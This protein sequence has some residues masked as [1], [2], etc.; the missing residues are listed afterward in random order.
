MPG[1]TVAQQTGTSLAMIK[2][3]AIASLPSALRVFALRFDQVGNLN[4]RAMK[5]ARRGKLRR[6]DRVE[7]VTAD[8][9]AK[10]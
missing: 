3:L 7:D 10:N 1:R 4:V 5:E 9:H 2:R 8:L 6:I